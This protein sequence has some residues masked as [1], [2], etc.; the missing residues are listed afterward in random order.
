MAQHRS[1]S[2]S[3]QPC[4]LTADDVADFFLHA[5][6][7]DSGLRQPVTNMRLQKLLYYAQAWSLALTGEPLFGEDIEAWEHGPVVRS[8]YTR[9]KKHGSHRLP[10]ELVR[11]PQLTPA[12]R[13]ILDAVWA[14]YGD[15]SAARLRAMAHRERPWKE[16]RQAYDEGDTCNV[17]LSHDAMREYFSARLGHDREQRLAQQ[18]AAYAR[19]PTTALEHA[20]GEEALGLIATS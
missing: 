10:T 17:P 4:M 2:E 19:Q 20:L 11:M 6:D 12:Q 3:Q 5:A 7:S 1:Y 9:F 14:S 13:S 18:R 8:V 16:A 15:V